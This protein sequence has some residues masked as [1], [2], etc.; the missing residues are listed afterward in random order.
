MR[1][2]GNGNNGNNIRQLKILIKSE[3]AEFKKRTWYEMY[4]QPK[5]E[6]TRKI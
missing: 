2:N 6:V 5:A 4:A 1:G 3:V